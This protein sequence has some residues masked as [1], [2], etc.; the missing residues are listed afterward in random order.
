MFSC[1][2][3]AAAS[4]EAKEKIGVADKLVQIDKSKIGKQEYDRGHVV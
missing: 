2:V 1:Q 3:Y 4:F